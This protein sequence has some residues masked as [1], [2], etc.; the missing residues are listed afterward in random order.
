MEGAEVTTGYYH[1][2]IGWIT[3]TADEK[4]ISDISFVENAEHLVKPTGSPILETFC[5]ELNNYFAGKLACFSTPANF[6][7][8]T[9]FQ[10]KVWNELIR[11]PL[12]QTRSYAQIADAIGHHRAFRAVGS[13]NATNPV[14]ILVP[15][16]RVINSSGSLG[17][18]SSGVSIKKGLLNLEQRFV[19]A[20]EKELEA[21]LIIVSGS[22]DEIAGKIAELK[23]IG[24]LKLAGGLEECFEDVYFD[25]TDRSLASKM[26]ALRVR[27]FANHEKIAFKGPASETID[28]VLERPEHEMQWTKDAPQKIATFLKELGIKIHRIKKTYTASSEEFLMAAGFTVI[29]RRHTTRTTRELFAEGNLTAVAELAI[30]RVTFATDKLLIAH[31]EVEIESLSP[32]GP[33]A[34]VESVKFLKRKFGASLMLWKYDKLTTV[35]VIKDLIGDGKLSGVSLNGFLERSAYNDVIAALEG[36]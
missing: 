23:H 6:K 13:A 4:G 7:R 28:G 21:K 32:S 17:G 15:C 27:H 10:K 26:W 11:I 24:S 31:Y 3:I 25:L 2:L 33:E 14:P 18:Y 19:L 16:H 22:P 30:D 9:E 36:R 20:S 1:Q 8:G 5:A 12:G 35:N 29:Q 34:I